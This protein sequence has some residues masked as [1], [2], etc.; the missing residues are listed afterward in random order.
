[1]RADILTGGARQDLALSRIALGSMA[2]WWFYG[3]VADNLADPDFRITGQ[4]PEDRASQQAWQRQ[5]L[6]PYSFCERAD[7]QW[8]CTSYARVDPDLG[9]DGHGGRHGAPRGDAPEQ[10]GDR[11]DEYSAMA[12]AAASGLY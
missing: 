10:R 4:R 9:A 8:R 2:M 1:M 6:Q 7:G 5:G 12:L 3:W 11:V